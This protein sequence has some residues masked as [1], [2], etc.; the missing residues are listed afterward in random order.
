LRDHCGAIAGSP[1][2]REYFPD[3]V[4]L[5]ARGM[6]VAGRLKPILYGKEYAF[7]LGDDGHEYYLHQGQVEEIGWEDLIKLDR[8][9]IV[10]QASPTTVEGKLPRAFGARLEPAPPRTGM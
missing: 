1:G 7:V 4:E 10:F 2:F 8:P 3:F 5:R 6:T 9:R